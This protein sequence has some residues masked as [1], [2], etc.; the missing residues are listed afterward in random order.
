MIT[1]IGIISGEIL[2]LID[3]KKRP[4]SFGEIRTNLDSQKDLTTMSIGWLIREKY[5]HLVKDGKEKYLCS[6]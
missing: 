6:C 1:Q 2:N 5:V 4:I 3:K